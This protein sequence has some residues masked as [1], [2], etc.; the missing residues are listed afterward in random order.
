MATVKNQ[1]INRENRE[2]VGEQFSED[3]RMTCR[4]VNVYY[5]E[6]QAVNSVSIDIPRNEVLAM[7]FRLREVDFLTLP[8][9]NER[10]H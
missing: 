4:D 10:Y 2:T 5:S 7:I 9:S 3:A 8:Q 6:K 1:L